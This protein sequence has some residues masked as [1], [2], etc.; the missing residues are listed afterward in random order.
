M[1]AFLERAAVVCDMNR[2]SLDMKYKVGASVA[3]FRR[4]GAMPALDAMNH[5][6]L[7]QQGQTDADSSAIRKMEGDTVKKDSQSGIRSIGLSNWYVEELEEFLPQISITPA[8]V[9]RQSC[10]L[11]K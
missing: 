5:F 1:Q 9:Q 11:I 2:G 3:A 6:F 10:F 8:L 7:N 4:G